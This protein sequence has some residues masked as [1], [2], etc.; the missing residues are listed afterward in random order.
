MVAR[1]PPPPGIIEATKP[2]GSRNMDNRPSWMTVTGNEKRVG[3]EPDNTTPQDN[4]RKKGR[5]W[6]FSANI[7]VSNAQI[8]APPMPL[9]VDNGLPGIELWLGNDAKDEMC[10]ICHMD[11]C[12][13]MNTC[14]L[15]VHQWLMTSHS[16][17]VAEYIQFDDA[18]PFEPL[19]LHCAVADLAKTESM[20]GKLTAIVRYWLRYKN[21]GKHVIL[22]FGLGESVMVNSIVGTLS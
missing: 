12:A 7:L 17:L 8:I 6:V 18:H 2:I 3:F 20:H 22:S 21:D 16:H 4:Q 11:T 19:R 5:L 9:D 1:L 13:A 10:F 14:N 15:A